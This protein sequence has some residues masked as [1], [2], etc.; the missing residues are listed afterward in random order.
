[1][2]KRDILVMVGILIGISI[3]VTFTIL[4]ANGIIDNP[5]P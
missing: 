2:D 3:P 1:M 5:I 4:L